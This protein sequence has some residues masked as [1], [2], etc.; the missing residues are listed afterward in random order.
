MRCIFGE[1]DG[2]AGIEPHFQKIGIFPFL[3]QANV[4]VPDRSTDS[5]SGSAAITAGH[6]GL[7]LRPGSRSSS[8]HRIAVR[9]RLTVVAFTNLETFFRFCNDHRPHSAFGDAAPLTPMGVNRV[10]VPLAINQ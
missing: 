1:I 8:R 7:P 5:T 9:S 10:Q 2:V 4:H 3:R 6:Q